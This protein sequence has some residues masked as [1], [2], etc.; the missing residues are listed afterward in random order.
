MFCLLQYHIIR[1]AD[2]IHNIAIVIG[3]GKGGP[4]ATGPPNVLIEG[5]C[6]PPPNNFTK[7]SKRW[8]H[9]HAGYCDTNEHALCM[10]HMHLAVHSPLLLV[11]H[12][13]FILSYCFK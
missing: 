10:L 5:A 4:G 11:M 9:T 13:T 6:S 12:I 8:A 3:V 7:C 1:H 2:L